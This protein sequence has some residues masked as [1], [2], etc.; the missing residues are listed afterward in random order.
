VRSIALA[1]LS[2][3]AS[4][5]TAIA[6]PTF[7][8]GSRIGLTPP[9]DMVISKRFSGFENPAKKSSITLVEM[10]ADAYRQLTAGLSNEA[11]QRQGVTVTGREQLKLQERSAVLIAGDEAASGAKVRKWVLAVADPT[12][13][14]FIVAQTLGDGGYSDTEMQNALRSVTF[15]APLSVSEQMSALSFRIGELAGFR[16]VR[17]ISGNSL[18]LTDGPQDTV[19]ALEQPILVLASSFG[20]P[21]PPGQAREQFARAA[22]A[23]NQTLKDLSIERSQAF[24][25]R[26][27]D[28]H[29][30]V[31]RGTD[32]V[33]GQP[34][35]VAQ[36][37]RFGL[38]K[39]IRMVGLTRADA[40]DKNLPRFRAVVD[41]V[42]IE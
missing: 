22:L 34:V 36:T 42:E 25:Q 40:R 14:G 27:Q 39:Y 12:A 20:S 17:V 4:L 32:A 11:L 10:P 41:S 35:V 29:E 15:R 7:P 19:K 31:A 21:P 2:L 30:I 16:P 33:S 3:L 26:G 38:E 24:R 1:V 18:L 28:W 13:T 37:I 6:Q 8:P 5:T 23:S 9:K